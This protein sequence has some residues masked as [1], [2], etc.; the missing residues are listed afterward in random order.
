MGD[1]RVRRNLLVSDSVG[2]V[3]DGN[4]SLPAPKISDREERA[5]R[6][7]VR[8]TVATLVVVQAALLAC[9]YPAKN[10]P[11]MIIGF[12]HPPR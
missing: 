10:N 1:S 9:A 3:P 11:Q 2:D 6:H 4:D 7:R 5:H 12:C 8:S